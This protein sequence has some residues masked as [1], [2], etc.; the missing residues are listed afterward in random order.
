MAGDVLVFAA[1]A[2]TV[3]IVGPLIHHRRIPVLQHHQIRLPI[4]RLLDNEFVLEW[5]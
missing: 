1:I 3:T 5:S 2:F 4:T